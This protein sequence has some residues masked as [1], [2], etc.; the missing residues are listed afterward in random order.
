MVG[1]FEI[2]GDDVAAVTS[3]PAAA[4]GRR[5]SSRASGHVLAQQRKQIYPINRQTLSARTSCQMTTDALNSIEYDST[6]AANCRVA[7]LYAI[8]VSVVV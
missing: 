1:E 6:D 4:G 8:V 2:V 5:V 7:L 3:T